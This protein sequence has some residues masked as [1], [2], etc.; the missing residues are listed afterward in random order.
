MR[1]KK[2]KQTEKKV[3]ETSDK[4]GTVH[5]QFLSEIQFCIFA[6]G[7]LELLT[8]LPHKVRGCV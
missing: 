3:V 6:K 5:T 8:L 1:I 2:A 4:N 7:L